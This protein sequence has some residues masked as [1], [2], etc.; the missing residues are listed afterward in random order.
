MG[1]RLIGKFLLSGL[2]AA[3]LGASI[4]FGIHFYHSQK[5]KGKIAGITPSFRG[6]RNMYIVK[7]NRENVSKHFFSLDDYLIKSGFEG[8]YAYVADLPVYLKDSDGKTKGFLSHWG[9]REKHGNWEMI[10]VGRLSEGKMTNL[11][12]Q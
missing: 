10:R 5:T 6:A 4:Y 9:Y 2:M 1:K 12:S 3:L 11:D 7:L 8:P